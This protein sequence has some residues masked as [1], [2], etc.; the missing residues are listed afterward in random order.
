MA[1]KIEY[2]APD[3]LNPAP[4]NP[5]T[6]TDDALA[7]L[8][9]LLDAHGFVDPVIARREDNLLIGGHQRLKANALR[10][11]PDAKVPVVYLEGLSDAKCKALNLA[12]NN[13]SAQG[14][15]DYP[16]LADA[17]QDIDTGEFD[18][19]SFTAFSADDIAGLMHGLDEHLVEDEA[20]E[21]LEDAVSET[22][23]LWLLS[24]HRL[25]CGDST[26]AEDVERVMG[27]GQ[28]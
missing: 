18:I 2:I 5:R 3:K 6:I 24:D 20:P 17:L 11:K 7:R 16:K 27:G 9:K 23:D 4:Y 21:L 22:G 10:S 1:V 12:L 13:P 25:L 28:G 19:P 15:F 26:K 14:E 8:V